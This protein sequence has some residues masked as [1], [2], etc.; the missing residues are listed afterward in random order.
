MHCV[1][2]DLTFVVIP[3]MTRL[4][5]IN[6]RRPNAAQDPK[7]QK[8]FIHCLSWLITYPTIPNLPMVNAAQEPQNPKILSPLS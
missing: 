8:I 6:F 5:F 3:Y 1:G 2:I 4:Y 7:T